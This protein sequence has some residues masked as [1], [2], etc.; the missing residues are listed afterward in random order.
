MGFAS[1]DTNTLTVVRTWTDSSGRTVR[2]SLVDADGTRVRL[3]KADGK[4]Y[5]V[6]LPDLSPADRDFVSTFRSGALLPATPT[7]ATSPTNTAGISVTAN[8]DAAMRTNW[9][10]Y[11]AAMSRLTTAAE[12]ERTA[13]RKT[14]VEKRAEK[15]RLEK[16]AKETE[17][18]LRTDAQTHKPYSMGKKFEELNTEANIRLNMTL[19][20][21]VAG[22]QALDKEISGCMPALDLRTEDCK[23]RIDGLYQGFKR[24]IVNG[25]NVPMLEMQEAYQA[26]P[27]ASK[28]GIQAEAVRAQMDAARRLQDMNAPATQVWVP[29]QPASEGH[30][31]VPAHWEE[32]RIWGQPR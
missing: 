15:A 30:P 9:A 26:E 28:Q 3:Q 25:A 5:A 11:G 32:R 2:A 20:G 17:K 6:Q 7:F 24:R 16:E 18:L 22:I 14:I 19:R 27:P 12:L 29:A 13:L 10:L 23:K 31:A 1:A 8:L 4:V 21:T